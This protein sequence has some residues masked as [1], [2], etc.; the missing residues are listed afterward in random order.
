MFGV[1]RAL[2]FIPSSCAHDVVVLILST[3]LPST[4][5][6]P[7]SLS[8]KE[9][10]IDFRVPGLSHAFVKEAEHVRVQKVVKKIENHHHRE[11]LQA[12]LQQ[13]NVYNPFS[14]NLKAMIRDMGNVELFELCKTIPK[15]QCS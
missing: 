10:E 4:L 5:C 11:A 15:M 2:H 7:P 1:R 9:H 6:C 13:N 8:Q 14:D 3:S 12:D